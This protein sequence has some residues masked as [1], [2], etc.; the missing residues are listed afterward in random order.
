MAA[1]A[2]NLFLLSLAAGLAIAGPARAG[3]VAGTGGATEITQLANNLQLVQMTT[4][5]MEQVATQLQQLQNMVT[6]TLSLPADAVAQITGSLTQLT[7]LVSRGEALA[8]DAQQLSNVFSTQNPSFTSPVDYANAYAQWATSTMSTINDALSQAGLD[9]SKFATESAALQQEEQL[10]QSAAGQKQAIQAGNLIAGQMV[11]QLQ[12]L[13]QTELT[14]AQ[15]QNAYLATQTKAQQHTNDAEKEFLA[16]P[17]IKTPAPTNFIN[18][19][20]PSTSS[21]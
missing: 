1:A 13:H 17:Q 11:T 6:N 8:Y 16:V 10:S 5:S 21:P 15:A 18:D 4:Q 3:S 20:A 9:A 19:F 12:A 14:Q 7:S 2:R